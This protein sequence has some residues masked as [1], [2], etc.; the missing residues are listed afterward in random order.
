MTV[1][2]QLEL[3][4]EAQLRLLTPDEI[5]TLSAPQSLDSIRE[6]RR[7][8]R[9]S[10]GIAQKALAAYISMWANT[11][12]AGGVIAVGVAD[13]GAIEGIL[14]AGVNHINDL[15]R[16]G[17][18]CCPDARYESKRVDILSNLGQPDQ[19]L[20]F[21]VPYH[22]KKVVRTTDKQAYDRR[23]GSK[24]TL[25]EDQIRE[26]QIEKGELSWERE[27]TLLKYPD[28]FDLRTVRK[29]A[30]AVIETRRL[31]H[32]KSME[33]V[34]VHRYL[35]RFNKGSF[36]PNKACALLFGKDPRLE[37]PGCYIRFLR[38][39]GKSEGL[40]EKRNQIKDEWIEGNLPFQLEQAERLI[41]AQ[42]REFSRLGKDGKFL[43]T[44]EYPKAAWFEAVVNAVAHRSYSIHTVPTFI[45]MFD[46]RIEV[47]SPG[48]FMPFVTSENIYERHEPRNPSIMEALFYLDRTKCSNEG[49]KRMRETMRALELP[50]P[51]FQAAHAGNPRVLVTLKNNVEQRKVWLDA[52]ASRIVGEAL[53]KLLTEHEK[54]IVNYVADFRRISVTDAVRITGKAWESSKALL[55]NLCTRGI[56]RHVHRKDILRDSKAHYVLAF[57]PEISN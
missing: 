42:L 2:E 44:Q 4:L 43:T 34:L 53:F 26:L 28:E 36:E 8:E 18:V 10:P 38:F 22:E 55:D 12:P 7:I 11:P 15:E 32:T 17:D 40:G 1:L 56:L 14:S 54:R 6:D 24:R 5:Y 35:G 45:K 46:D 25:N 19:I 13:N 9:K 33:E 27:A 31:E 47:E 57:A 30:D 29:F 49:T 51:L 23:G 21:R 50:E 37:V 16:A 3:S 39:D 41:G 48:G 20:L 52:D